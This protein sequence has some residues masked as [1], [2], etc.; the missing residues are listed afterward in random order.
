MMWLDTRA[1]LKASTVE[2][3]FVSPMISL[4]SKALWLLWLARQMG[5]IYRGPS[6]RGQHSHCGENIRNT[7]NELGFEEPHSLPPS[8]GRRKAITL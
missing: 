6:H 5:P 2:A 8:G 7:K 3:G 4:R 1:N